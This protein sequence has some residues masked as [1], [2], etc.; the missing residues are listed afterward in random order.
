MTQ[1][2]LSSELAGLGELQYFVIFEFAAVNVMCMLITSPESE[3]AHLHIG[4]RFA[5][6]F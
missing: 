2:T 1:S 3:L 4:L 5:P 6:F